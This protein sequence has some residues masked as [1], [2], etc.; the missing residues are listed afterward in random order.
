VFGTGLEVL[1][2]VIVLI[3]VLCWISINHPGARIE[4]EHP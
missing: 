2:I 4:K 3:V 1:A